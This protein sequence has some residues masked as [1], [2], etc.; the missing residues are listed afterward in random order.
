MIIQVDSREKPHAIR[1]ILKTFDGLGIKHISS[2]LLVGDY[3]SLDNP[4]LIIDRKQNLLELC[5][6]LCQD[7]DRFRAEAKLAKECGIR[8]IILVEHGEGIK[9]LE[10]VI[11]WENPRR[12]TSP[13]AVNGDRLYKIMRTFSRKYGVE[14]QFCEKSETGRVIVEQLSGGDYVGI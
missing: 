1:Q 2:K 6:N 13:K 11:F 8:L 14:F 7:H 10:D 4:R 3:M 9:A 12:Q 5:Q